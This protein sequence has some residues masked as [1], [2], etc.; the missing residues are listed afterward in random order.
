MT[1]DDLQVSKPFGRCGK[2]NHSLDIGGLYYGFDQ[3]LI[4]HAEVHDLRQQQQTATEAHLDP[5]HSASCSEIR[6]SH[7]YLRAIKP[8]KPV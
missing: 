4:L 1:A 3:N 7:L 8:M 5:K 6:L 2:R